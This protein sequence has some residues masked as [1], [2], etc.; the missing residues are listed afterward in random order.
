MALE[1]SGAPAP[2]SASDT[3][4]SER[5]AEVGLAITSASEQTVRKVIGGAIL[6][7]TALLFAARGPDAV[8]PDRWNVLIGS[9]LSMIATGVTK[10]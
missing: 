8:V 10:T 9:G 6:A 1:V 2:S 4:E 5:P 7:F 3:T